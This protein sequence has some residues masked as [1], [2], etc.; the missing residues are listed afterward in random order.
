[1][2]IS[3]IIIFSEKEIKENGAK[4]IFEEVMAESFS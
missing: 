2:R 3:N 1:M 4:A